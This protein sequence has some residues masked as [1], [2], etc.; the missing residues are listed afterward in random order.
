MW[1]PLTPPHRS[2]MLL[3]RGADRDSL[4]PGGAT[5][6]HLAALANQSETV[7]I[8]LNRGA[9]STVCDGE[10][11]TPQ[12]SSNESIARIFGDFSAS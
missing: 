2:W 6:L 9:D 3:D 11:N 7:R 1:L 12:E 8:L 10:G 5:P 4:G